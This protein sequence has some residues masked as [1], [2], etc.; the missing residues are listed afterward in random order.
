MFTNSMRHAAS[1]QRNQSTWLVIVSAEVRHRSTQSVWLVHRSS[2]VWQLPVEL[3]DCL[4]DTIS[5]LPQAILAPF[6]TF[7]WVIIAWDGYN[8]MH[9]IADIGCLWCHRA[10][11]HSWLAASSTTGGGTVK[12]SYQRL[13]QTQ[14]QPFSSVFVL[15]PLV[16][17][18]VS[19]FWLA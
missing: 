10:H 11:L 19:L 14:D 5:T 2:W 3:V 15:P 6:E 7:S 13:L 8:H 12:I 18:L 16:R 1:M 4:L 17:C 9:T